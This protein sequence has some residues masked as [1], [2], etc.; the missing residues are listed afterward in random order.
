MVLRHANA[1]NIVKHRGLS[2]VINSRLENL[3]AVATHGR[4]DSREHRQAHWRMRRVLLSG[5]LSVLR[6]GSDDH[7]IPGFQELS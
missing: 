7:D 5:G 4:A 2:G 3:K 6:D 1:C